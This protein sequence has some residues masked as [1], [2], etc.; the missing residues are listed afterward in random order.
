[1][2]FKFICFVYKTGSL[3]HSTA[4]A[5]QVFLSKSFPHFSVP[6]NGQ[7]K[8]LRFKAVALFKHLVM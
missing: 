1:M 4:N 7:Q 6:T 8:L 5:C 2:Y 3:Y